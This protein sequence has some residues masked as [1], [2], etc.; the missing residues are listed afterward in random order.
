[1]TDHRAVA[2]TLFAARRDRTAIPPITDADP[3]LTAEDGYAIQQDLVRLLLADGGSIV[4][5]KLGLTSK[6]MQQLI[7]V[8]QPDYGPVLS[9][10]VFDDGASIDLGHY[11]QPKVETEI[12]LILDRHLRGPGVTAL[13]AAQAIRGAVAAIELVD[14]S[15]A[16]GSSWSTPSPTSPRR[17]PSS[18]ATGSCASMAG[19]S[20]CVARWSPGTGPRW[21]PGPAPRPWAAQC[22]P[23][24]G[25][26]TR[27][28]PSTSP[29]SRTTS[30]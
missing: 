19:T 10:T 30:S 7:G 27:L 20:A 28:G 5:Y 1:V 21:R 22:M 13:Q 4:G 18:S 29:S 12:A 14:G 16:G 24:H 26:P 15:S 23:W 6:P 25:W 11:I 17:R 9:P 8:D 2:E 3:S